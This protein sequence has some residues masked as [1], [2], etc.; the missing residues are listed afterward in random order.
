[1]N[2]QKLTA[3]PFTAMPGASLLFQHYLYEN[4]RVIDLYRA[5]GIRKL[6]DLAPRVAAQSYQR[7]VLADALKRQNELFGAG[8][9]TFENI[10]LLR[11]PETVAIVTG[12]QAGLFSGPLYTIYKA[13]TAIK[14]AEKV[15]ATGISV[16][17][18]F[19]VASEDHDYQEVSYIH[20]VDRE[21]HLN[22][23]KHDAGEAAGKSSVG[24]LKLEHNIEAS[25]NALL[26]QLPESEFTQQLISHLREA[27]Q[28]GT[29]FAV[30]FAKLLAK[31][32]ADYGVILLDPQDETCKQLA[33]PVYE[34]ALLNS[35]ELAQALVAQSKTL[36]SAGYHAQI[37][38]HAEMSLLLVNEDGQR[39]AMVQNGENFTL[40][41]SGKSYTRNEMLGKLELHAE[42][43]SPGVALRAVVQ[44]HLLPTIAYIAGPAELAYFAQLKPVYQHYQRV[45]PLI[46]ARAGFTVI[47]DR[48]QHLLQKFDLDFTA[49]FN[50]QD[51]VF[52]HIIE[53]R[54]DNETTNIF[55]ETDEIFNA[56][57]E[58]LRVA[59]IKV[60]PTLADAL[61]G[62]KDK[63][64]YQ[65]HNLRTRFVNSSA[66]REETT[67]RQLEK[68]FAVLYPEK[69]LQERE[70]NVYYFLARYGLEFID[71]I[72]QNIEI[73]VEPLLSTS[74][75][76]QLLLI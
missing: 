40:K 36:E 15:R 31:L 72:Y 56:Q 10:E 43:F 35:K 21:G 73:E 49:L 7:E 66:K 9:K 51:Q 27:Y 22:T 75:G 68:L 54:A 8:A 50:G 28:P 30:A 32:F 14:L 4:D 37:H 57:L 76:H 6:A 25:I 59:L 24:S 63:I 70:L 42:L 48:F 55:N 53:S 52:R 13:L 34:K 19:W 23:I 1:M 41:S 44:D 71:T 69:N 33:R 74:A 2:S 17:P 18:I 3:I 16:V 62:S 47:Q 26:N 61:H 64:F 58:K 45:A 60:E 20:M 11:K 12:Q 39:T 65:L 46:I 38:T 29:G 5:D 67:A